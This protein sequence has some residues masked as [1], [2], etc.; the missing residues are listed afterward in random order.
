METDPHESNLTFKTIQSLYAVEIESTGQKGQIQVVVV[1]MTTWLRERWWRGEQG[2]PTPLSLFH[3]STK[4][5]FIY[6]LTNRRFFT[7]ILATGCRLTTSGSILDIYLLPMI[8]SCPVVSQ[9]I[10]VNK[11]KL[12]ILC[13]QEQT[14]DTTQYLCI[15]IGL[16]L[17]NTL[18][19][20]IVIRYFY[21]FFIFNQCYSLVYR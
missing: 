6:F 16:L 21:L 3:F 19:L 8:Y 10:F 7:G 14:L 13:Q 20:Y 12:W 5:I 17:P 2:E 9:R 1:V 4:N 15:S 18:G 11:N